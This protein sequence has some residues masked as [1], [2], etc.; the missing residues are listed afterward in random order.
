MN[1][2]KYPG[3]TE[4]RI[5]VLVDLNGITDASITFAMCAYI[6]NQI[7]RELRQRGI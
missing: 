1:D 4:L 3:H 7:D 5:R 2:I 6:V